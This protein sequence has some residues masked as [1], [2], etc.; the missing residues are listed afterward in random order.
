MISNTVPL[1]EALPNLFVKG[2]A[3]VVQSSR[4]PVLITP[5]TILTMDLLGKYVLSFFYEGTIIYFV[6][7]H[8]NYP[9]VGLRIN[10]LSNKDQYPYLP[11]CYSMDRRA[12]N[13]RI[14]DAYEKSTE[15]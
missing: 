3:R 14:L 6:S 1:H 11:C 8:E 12:K 5:E 4:Q 2:Y 10:S 13:N 9:Y 15:C 7:P